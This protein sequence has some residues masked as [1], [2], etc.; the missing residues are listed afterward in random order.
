M[1]TEDIILPI[2]AKMPL[3]CTVSPSDYPHEA[4]IIPTDRPS[5]ARGRQLAAS[6]D[7]SKIDS[8]ESYRANSPYQVFEALQSA[9]LN[10][11]EKWD[12][13]AYIW[14]SETTAHALSNGQELYAQNCAACHGENDGGNGV[15]AD[16]VAAAGEASMQRMDGA[17]SLA[18]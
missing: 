6:L 14:Q 16:D 12:V 1:I 13:V 15:F 17:M 18:T 8:P 7:I 2:P 4:S 5:A 11:L 9:S 10:D 3:P